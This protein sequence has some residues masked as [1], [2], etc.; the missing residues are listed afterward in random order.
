MVQVSGGH[1]HAM[2][3]LGTDH[4]AEY[5]AEDLDGDLTIVLEIESE[6]DGG[7]ASMTELPL[8]A[9][10]TAKGR[11]EAFWRIGHRGRRCSRTGVYASLSRRISAPRRS[12]S[13]APVLPPLSRE[14]R[15][16][17]DIGCPRLLDAG[18]VPQVIRERWG[19]AVAPTQAADEG[20]EWCARGRGA[21]DP[22]SLPW[23]EAM[24]PTGVAALIPTDQV[25]VACA[26]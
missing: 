10:G 12:R 1:D 14:A 6:V 5:G 16:E 17:P 3:P 23:L 19:G 9:I 11:G 2:A 21:R 25:R 20:P 4:R 18:Q 24:D 7:H 26:G 15:H 8:D 22:V 13:V